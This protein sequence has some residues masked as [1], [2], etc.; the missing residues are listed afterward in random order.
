MCA[1]SSYNVSGI[2]YYL[3]FA[4]QLHFVGIFSTGIL[5]L[6]SNN[7]CGAADAK[8]AGVGVAHDGHCNLW[9]LNANVGS[10]TAVRAAQ[11]LQLVHILWL[12]VAGLLIVLGSV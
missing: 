7:R 2:F 5:I 3:R 11:S 9:E 4:M 1:C 10:T 6:V 12:V 8:C